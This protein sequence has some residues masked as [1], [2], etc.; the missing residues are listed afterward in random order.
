MRATRNPRTDLS[1]TATWHDQVKLNQNNNPNKNVEERVMAR[2]REILFVDPSVSDI[3]TILNGLR[4]GVEAIVLDPATPA[5]RQIAATLAGRHG[6]SA[7]HIIAHGAPGRVN[8][9]SGDWSATTLEDEAE[10]FAAI[11]RALAVDGEL[12]LWSCDT[13]AG[14]AGAAF[15]EGLAEATG[16]DVA[17][18][19]GR[20]GAAALGGTWDLAAFAHRTPD[21]PPLT[22]AAMAAY[23]GVLTAR[24]WATPG[25]SGTWNTA[26]NWSP[27]GVPALGDTVT[28]GSGSA[29]TVTLNIS[30][31][32]LPSGHWR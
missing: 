5:V 23:A 1:D 8:F 20:I 4:P 32:R 9:A 26:G 11:G 29:Y 15:I 21:R 27:S 6:L 30:P 17:A 22:A 7:V 25:T 13:G 31:V 3:D 19:T 28:L 14:A 10:N 24:S 18:S 12:R 16:A 2:P